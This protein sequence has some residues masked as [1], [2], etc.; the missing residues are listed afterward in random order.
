M[1]TDSSLIT[2][3]SSPRA[4]SWRSHILREFTPKVARLTLV[5]DPDGLLL[6]EGIL[7]GIRERGF[8]L[9]RFLD[10]IEFRYAY[11]SRYRSKWDQGIDTDL[12]VV[13]STQ[14]SSL[15]TLPYDLLQAGRKLS[16]NLGDIFPNLSYPVVTALDR[17]DL[18][19]LYEAQKRYAPGQLGD[20]ATRDF[21][22]RHVFEIAPELIKQP[23]DLLRV[24][25][26]R[27][28]HGQ[29]IPADLDRRFIQ[30][31]RQNNTFDG[32]PLETLVTD[33]EA[34]F[35]FLQER[36]PIFL[37]RQAAKGASGVCEDE[38]PYI[39]SIEG[40]AELPFDHHD[41]RVYIDNLFVEGLLHSVSHEHASSL[42][43]TWVGIGVRTAPIE[44]RSRRLGKLIES[45]EASIPTEDAK[46]T[47]WFLFA[48]RWAEVKVMSN[49]LWVMS[50]SKTAVERLAHLEKAV[51]ERF[52]R[53]IQRRFAGLIQLPPNPPVMLHHIPRFLA[54]S[55]LSPHHSS[56]RPKFAL[57]VLD[58]L[59]L[60]QWLVVREALASKEPGLRFREQAVFAW[61]PSLTSDSRQA[62][63]AGKAP[64]FFPNSIHTTDKE[65]ILW[66]QF[67][68]D[69]GLTPNEVVYL[70]GLGDGDMETVSEA[71]SHPQ[72][73][74]A[75]LVVDK[76]DK[77]MH[78]MEL[79]TAGMYNQVGQWAKEQY[80]GTLLDMLLDRGFQVYLTSDHGNLE[81]QGCGRPAEGAVADLR[82]E[83]VRIYSNAVLRGKVKERFPSAMEWGTT[84][85]PEDYLALLAP[86]RQAFVQE[87]QRTVCHG[88][89]SIEELIVPL[90][91]I[92][93]RGE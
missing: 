2:Q 54:N 34:F 47:D 48:R 19:A 52:I 74:V 72:A 85:L 27:H 18:D 26:R 1:T 58:G 75:G 41:I 86:P 44:D 61:I 32:W 89:I 63:F 6:E 3:S 69:Q 43:K 81:A 40:P 82:G 12:V 30:L 70:K 49:E 83:R 88:G 50:E 36:W 33:R 13:L 57:L 35:A 10:P 51:D 87:N 55:L 78:G 60:D 45:M 68:A 92:E 73:R 7:E 16:F 11:E 21:V 84:G 93:R 62:I 56:P 66:A 65:P 79:G 77:I 5:A 46:H 8:E 15:I 42:S 25:L 31:L 64:L 53:W 37:D 39:L 67:W 90:V 14:S 71:L 80:L 22:L 28:Y 24:L 23:S 76:V 20:N 29:R 4:E 38:K 9:I 59:A 17:G 91:Q